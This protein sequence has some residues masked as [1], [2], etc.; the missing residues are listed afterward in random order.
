MPLKC[1][2]GFI[3]YVRSPT[4]EEF[5]SFPDIYFLPELSGRKKSYRMR[6]RTGGSFHFDFGRFSLLFVCLGLVSIH[7]KRM[8]SFLPQ[9]I[10]LKML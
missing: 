4:K 2:E 5:V 1:V 8:L 3:G 10:F 7:K 6:V 9:S